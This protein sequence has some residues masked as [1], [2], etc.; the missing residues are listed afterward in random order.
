MKTR[1]TEFD[2]DR[3]Y[4]RDI[5]I[6]G[7]VALV[8][9]T[10]AFLFAPQ[11]QVAPYRLRVPAEWNL[12]IEDPMPAI[13]DPPKPVERPPSG[14]PMAS[15]NPE[16]PT[17][18]P[19]TGF[20]E[21]KPDV[22]APALETNVPFWKVERK[23]RLVR[24]VVPD[25]PDMAR[26]AGIEGKVLVSMVIDTLGNVASAEVFATSGNVLLDRAAVDA[27]YKCGF[28]PG[29]QRDRPVVVHNVILPFSF[30]LQ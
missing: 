13:Y 10:V 3:E 30:R 23:P 22:T 18:A 14:V 1:C 12:T 4:G 27:A 7:A 28:T 25:Y 16:A 24:E 21:L 9:V 5:R 20:K 2:Y 8:V 26:V 17:I 15:D 29:Y 11:P 19:N 6:A